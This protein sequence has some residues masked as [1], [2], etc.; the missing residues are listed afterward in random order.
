MYCKKCG[1][2]I[3]DEAVICPKCGCATDN[4]AQN[5]SKGVDKTSGGIIVAAIFL[6]IVGLIAG[7]V[8]LCNKKTNSGIAYL[9]TGIV[10]WIV[11]AGIFA[12]F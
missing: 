12:I 10:A 9:I 11:W 8:N 1:A 6:P 7:I 3:D 4:Y 5:T 2:Q